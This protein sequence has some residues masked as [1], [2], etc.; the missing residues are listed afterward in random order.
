MPVTRAQINVGD[1]I[2]I[3]KD[4]FAN[5]PPFS[6]QPKLIHSGCQ[7]SVTNIHSTLDKI[8]VD[9]PAIGRDFEFELSNVTLIGVQPQNSSTG[10]TQGTTSSGPANI[11]NIPKQI[12]SSPDKIILDDLEQSETNSEPELSTVLW[13]TKFIFPRGEK[14]RTENQSQKFYTG[15]YITLPEGSF[16]IL[17]A[18]HSELPIP[19]QTL[20]LLTDRRNSGGD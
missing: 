18:E 15:E 4:C 13:E 12:G 17:A 9:L 6:G 11:Q 7:G 16:R 8:L 20:Y 5:S 14:F 10:T 2:R 1:W 19:R 3:D